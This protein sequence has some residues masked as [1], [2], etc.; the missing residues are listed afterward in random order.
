[1]LPAPGLAAYIASL[2]EAALTWKHIERLARVTKL[3][4]LVKGVPV[5]HG[6]S[7]II[8][9]PEISPRLLAASPTCWSMSTGPT[10]SSRSRCRSR[11]TSRVFRTV[12]AS[13]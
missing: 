7:G 4:V 6:A 5:D 10:R 8:L 2:F 1:M 12:R 9:L 13:D 3:P 11:M